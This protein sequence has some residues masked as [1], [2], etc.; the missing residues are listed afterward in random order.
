VDINMGC[1]AKKITCARAGA[2][3][4]RDL[5]RVGAI[6]RAMRRVTRVPL[7]VK[8]R[9]DWGD[10]QAGRGAALE[11]MR[12]AESEGLD[13]VCL[14]ARTREQGYS[15]AANWEL[16]AQLKAAAP[17]KPLVGNGDIRRPADALEMLRRGGCEAVMIGRAVIGDPWLLAAALRAGRDGA[18]PADDYAPPWPDRRALML[19]HARQLV[20]SRGPHGVVQFRKHA[21]AYLRGLRGAKRLR[22]RL[23][24]VATLEELAAVLTP[25]A[26]DES[27]APAADAAAAGSSPAGD[28]P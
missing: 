14:H 22:T 1:P 26:L 28:R 19:E 20:A 9:W 27:E 5:P 13:G 17:D 3:L 21:A 12:L 11:V 2:A 16:I 6:F 23:M 25:D 8:L 24:Q 7:T 4:L 10:G 18:A 15:G